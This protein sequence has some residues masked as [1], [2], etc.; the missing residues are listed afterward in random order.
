MKALDKFFNEANLFK[1]F[2]FGWFFSAGFTFLIFQF[3]PDGTEELRDVSLGLKVGAALGIPLGLIT[4]LTTL[5][6]RKSQKFWDYSKEV[7]ILV[8]NAKTK[9]EIRSVYNNEFKTL[10]KLSQGGPHVVELTKLSA[11][12]N[13]KYDYAK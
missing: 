8:D 12:L 6:F 7:Q 11:I 1:V 5:S 9:E 4:A 3:M 2:I 10:Q 13:T